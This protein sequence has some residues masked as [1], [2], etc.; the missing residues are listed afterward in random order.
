MTNEGER[1]SKRL[2]ILMYGYLPPPYFGPST[3]YQVM[4]K[5]SFVQKHDMELVNLSIV[6]DLRELERFSWRKI[7]R[8]LRFLGRTVLLVTVRKYDFC[9]YPISFNRNAF[10]KDC[11][12]LAPIRWR[13]VPIVLFAHGNNL[14]DFYQRS[15][16]VV[17]WLIDRT[18]SRARAALVLGE[19]LC[20]N[21]ADW[22]PPERVLS[23]PLG[24]DDN[25]PIPPRTRHSE[26][27]QCV[28]LGNLIPEKG[29]FVLLKAIP[30]VVARCPQT[31]FVF[32]GAW[33]RDEH[34]H[35]AEQLIN[36]L[37]IE[38]YVNFIGVVVGEK[39]W[40]LLANADVLVF[41]TFYY[42]E[43]SPLVLLEAMRA[44]L[45]IVTT[46]RGAIP[47]LVCERT[48]GFFVPEQNPEAL[49]EKILELVQN[50]E[51]RK[52]MGIASR[53]RF[54]R[55]FTS[56][57]FAGR[58]DEAFQRLASE[59][60]RLFGLPI[61]NLTMTETVD[62][63]EELIRR[64]PTHQHVVVNVDKI[65][66]MDKDPALRKAILDCDLINADGQPIVWASRWLGCPLK[67]RVTGIDLFHALIVRC[68]ERGYRPFL[69]GARDEVVR[70]VAEI[71]VARHPTLKIAGYRNGYW[72]PD[73]EAQVAEQIRAARPDILFV[74]I[75]SP[76][77]ELFVNRWKTT[78][79]VPFVMGVGGTFDVVAG[80]VKRAPRWM[81]RCGLEWFYRLCQ[82]PGRM[83]RRYLV[84]DLAFFAIVW[85]EWRQR[86][87]QR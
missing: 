34:R 51:L 71:L 69:L 46:A 8:L 58:L 18:V 45:P 38:K 33:C 3:V 12:L 47:E 42:Y 83:W 17:Q 37:A 64:G 72:K 84:D 21:F 19:R 26:E 53:E 48:N 39:K 27:I 24:I 36:Q 43:A 73:E 10:L 2:R 79:Q 23:V 4:L 57:H 54:K 44:G 28:Y 82:E 67:E 68:A 14:P 52:N 22:L 29:I 87:R 41:P 31:R 74:A 78:M 56:E 75:S 86:R 30:A 77:K 55:L 20:F 5:S 11:L 62:H 32:A 35:E 1:M 65:V 60:V 25:D 49:A 7:A 40:E 85:R 63:I 81:Q 13:G 61:A 80:L 76:K 9:C 15:S 59:P 50:P 70:K 6:S 16:P 66:K